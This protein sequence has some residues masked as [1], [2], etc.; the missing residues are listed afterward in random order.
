MNKTRTV[1]AGFTL[2]E[3]MITMLII[4]IISYVVAA[5]FIMSSKTMKT[6]ER[7]SDVSAFLQEAVERSVD[8][9]R[10]ASSIVTAAPSTITVVIN[11]SQMT[12]A[13]DS[14]AKTITKNGGVL[15]ANISGCVITYYDA[16]G[17]ATTTVSAI[18]SAKFTINGNSGGEP[19]TLEST[20]TFRRL[21][22]QV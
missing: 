16:S 6:M 5:G 21:H 2:I 14:T 1:K 15:G 3:M 7:R 10:T 20:V 18:K 22:P 11:G 19:W 12:I 13:Y 9:L 8:S 17:T 4:G